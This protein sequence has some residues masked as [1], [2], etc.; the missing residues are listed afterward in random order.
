MAFGELKIEK[1]EFYVRKAVGRAGKVKIRVKDRNKKTRVRALEGIKAVK[2]NIYEDFD[3][4]EKNFPNLN[5]TAEF[6]REIIEIKI[7]TKKLKESIGRINWTKNKAVQLYKDYAYRI[8]NSKNNRIVEKNKREYYGRVSSI[9]RKINNELKFLE[10]A[11]RKIKELPNIKTKIKT[12]C[13][14]GFPNVGKSTL[15]KKLTKANV[16]I[17]PYAFT[18]KDIMMGYIGKELQV[19]DT[20]GTLNRYDRMNDIEKIA[21]TAMKHLGEVII[22]VFDLT[23]SCGYTVKQQAEL[24]ENIEREHKKEILVY[25]SKRDRIKHE[26]ILMFRI[27]HNKY[28]V[29]DNAE[30][31]KEYLV[32]PLTPIS[33]GEK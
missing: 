6:Y 12:A 14:T 25:L 26:K 7:G 1:G 17:K 5:T 27:A 16:E 13:I 19:I 8:K 31:L 20:P 4:I 15:L 18:T 29:F 24:L 21:H 3:R 30:K 28:K 33:S 2:D 22:Y 32:H 10:E 23:E 11:R 9:T